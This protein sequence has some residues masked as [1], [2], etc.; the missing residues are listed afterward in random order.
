MGCVCFNT[1]IRKT[2]FIGSYRHAQKSWTFGFNRFVS[3]KIH[4]VSIRVQCQWAQEIVYTYLCIIVV[5]ACSDLKFIP[6][7]SSIQLLLD[8]CNQWSDYCPG[9]SWMILASTSALG[10]TWSYHQCNWCP[11]YRW[12]RQQSDNCTIQSVI[13][14]SITVLHV[15]D[16]I[17]ITVIYIY[18]YDYCSIC[19][20]LHTHHCD[21]DMITYSSLLYMYMITY[22]S[23]WY[24]WLHTHYC[25]IYD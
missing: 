21:I 2:W 19:I 18:I 3:Q 1:Q 9:L 10:D 22:S 14:Q 7:L 12:S 17:I 23:L 8:S 16:Y 24:I 13:F 11:Y 6:A 5:Y 4:P 15:Y 20:W 25:D